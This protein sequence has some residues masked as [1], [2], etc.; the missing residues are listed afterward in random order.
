MKKLEILLIIGAVIGLIMA[1]LNV[2]L[3]S[4][5]LSVFFIGLSFLYFYLG[6]ALFNGI[7]ARDIFKAGSYEGLGPW[8]IATAIGTGIALSI[9]TIGFMFAILSYHMA[10]T[11]LIVGTVATAIVIILALVRNAIDKNQFYRNI[12]LRC[13]VFL[14]ITIILLLI[15]GHISNKP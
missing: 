7:R 15:P 4:L 10:T 11:M 3:H 13:L 9:L 14:I 2:P 8:R 12:I 1:L 5:I 6:F